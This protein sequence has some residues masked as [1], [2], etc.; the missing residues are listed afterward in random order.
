MV[1][2]YI[3]VK[4]I[5]IQHAENSIEYSI[6]NTKYRANGYCKE[7]YCKETNTIYECHRTIYSGDPRCCRPHDFNYLGKNYG[8][9]Y[10]KTLDKEELSK[11]L[12]YNLVVMW[13]YDWIKINKCIK[14]IQQKFK[15][16]N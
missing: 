12:G 8:Y 15:N 3:K 16:K 5:D 11:S 4:N 10:Q 7:G 9:L 6:S 13:E 2:F 14:R 1:K